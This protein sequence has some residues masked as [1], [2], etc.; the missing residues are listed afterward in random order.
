MKLASHTMP[1]LMRR[2]SGINTDILFLASK[3]DV[4]SN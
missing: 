3:Q 2:S 1:G 4:D